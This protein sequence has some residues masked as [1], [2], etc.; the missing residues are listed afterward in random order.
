MRALLTLLIGCMLGLT[1]QA[2]EIP[3][4]PE[5]LPVRELK[6]DPPQPGDYRVELNSGPVAYLV[7]DNELP[8]INFQVMIRTGQYLDPKGK[9]GLSS[10]TGRL[11]T[12]GGVGERSA[13]EF[14]EHTA[15]LAA[16]VGSSIGDYSGS[17]GINLLSKDTDEGLSLLRQ[18]LTQPRFEEDRIQLVKSQMLQ[19]M[20]QR[21][22][23]SRSIEARERGFLT[24]GED[25]FTNEH[26]TEASINAITR[27][28]M[29]AF[30]KEWFHPGNFMIAVNGDFKKD[31]MKQKLEKLFS[32]WPIKGKTPPAIPTNISFADPGLYLVNKDVNQGRVNILMPGVQRDNPDF[33]AIR[34]MNDILGGGGFTSRIM[35]RVRSDEGLAYSAGSHFPGGTY[36]P[37]I[38][39]AG[40]QSKSRTVAYASSIVLEEIER[41]RKEPVTEEEL[42]VAKRSFIDTF[43]QTFS[44]KSQIAGTF[45]DDEFTGRHAEDPNYWNTFRDKIEAVTIKEVQ[46]VAKKYLTPDKVV[47]L[48]VGDAEEILKGHPDHD[49]KLPDLVGGKVTRVPLRDPMTLKP[50]E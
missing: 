45:L 1:S 29:V 46:R 19:S 15:F 17:V 42:N 38:F 47:I 22:D 43:P 26:T 23:D 34:V 33:F 14:E 40:F 16:Q 13:Q 5:K 6:Y 4:R 20:K 8:L 32:G 36:F 35:N 49:V 12:Q 31:E 30:H 9:E 7:Q 10:M 2:S 11:L 3:D 50:M 24:R 25:F 44:T 39:M 48:V 27:E 18:I 21:N 37:S 28:D 41:I